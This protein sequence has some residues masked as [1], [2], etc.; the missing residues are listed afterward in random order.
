MGLFGTATIFTDYVSCHV[1]DYQDG[2]VWMNSVS[3]NVYWKVGLASQESV[4][5][6]FT[7]DIEAPE[8]AAVHF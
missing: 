6:P 5:I 8:G 2:I 4:S 3:N 1:L 7:Y